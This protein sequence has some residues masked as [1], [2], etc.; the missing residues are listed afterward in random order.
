MDMFNRL[1]PL[2]VALCTVLTW[3]VAS[4]LS[5]QEA[6][7]APGAEQILSYD[8]DITVNPDSTLLVRET[9][10]VLATRAPIN[11]GFSRDIPTRYHDRFGN[12]YKIHMEVVSLERD[13]QP[14]E[15]HLEKTSNGL[16]ICMGRSSELVP[17]GQP[18]F[19]L[20]YSVDREIG[21]FPDHDELYWNVTG[22]GWIFP[23]H[24]A[25]ATLH[26][27]EGI[28]QE[29]ILLDAYTGRQDSVGTDYT[30][31]ADGQ[32]NATFRTTRALGP[33]E[34]LAIVTRWPKGFVRPPTDS[35]KNRYFLEDNQAGLIGFAGIVLVLIYYTAAW[36]LG[37][38]PD[39]G[40][41][42]PRSEPPQGFSP[43]AVRYAWRGSFDRMTMVVNL[44]D[45]AVKR[46]LAILEEVSGCYI[47][48][49]LKSNSPTTG[50]PPRARVARRP[51]ITGDEK[52]VLKKL[53]AADD[54]IPLVPIHGAI[55]GGTIEA[56]HRHL[57]TS[58]EK[59]RFMAN[60][61]YLIPGLLISLATVVRCGFSIQGAP[62]PL[63]FFL[64]LWLLPWSLACLALGTLAMDAWKNALSDPHHAPAARQQALLMSVICLLFLIGEVA[65]LS[66]LA[67][68]ASTGA[69]VVLALLAVVNYVFHYLRKAPIRSGRGLLDQ[70][71]GFR[72]FLA[73]T[74]WRHRDA[75][76]ARNLT[77]DLF[78]RFLPY[79]MALN[80]EKVW[81]EKFAAVLAQTASE[82]TADYSPVWYTGPS[83]NRI[84]PATFAAS[85]GNSLSSALA[86][87]AKASGS[88]SGGRG[89]PGSRGGARRK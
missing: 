10:R 72:Q 60:A 36:R 61:R 86:S 75:R 45:L 44:V 42:A 19:E 82:G 70:I 6:A 7:L 56:L 67:W 27:P 40:E 30:A 65:G 79:A 55:V 50:A 29:A 43:A 88:R 48:G 77:P 24:Q 18:T 28:A 37:R 63:V 20:T 3:S 2:T 74:E 76:V 5:V 41:I 9:I 85:L 64:A 80:V 12:P 73:T 54:T 89:S 66:A 52:L 51:E 47:L 31:S 38:K 22:H 25:S 13:G 35:Q 69:A 58:M 16:R 84:T 8:S 4:V 14:E 34:G 1:Q 62:R 71:E 78:E 46:Q 11:H 23:I 17:P 39:R 33:Y 57:R 68:A 26:L 15:F 32:S 53:F 21:F 81:S 49:R 59:V 87:S 83:R